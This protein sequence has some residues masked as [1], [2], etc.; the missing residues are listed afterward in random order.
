MTKVEE[1]IVAQIVDNN[2]LN[3]QKELEEAFPKFTFENVTEL[4]S[5]VIMECIKALLMGNLIEVNVAVIDVNE[6]ELEKKIRKKR[7]PKPESPSGEGLA[8]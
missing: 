6:Q 5:L 1:R 8:P 3:I 4:S 2:T 7:T